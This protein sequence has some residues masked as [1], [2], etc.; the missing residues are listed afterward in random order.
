MLRRKRGPGDPRSRRSLGPAAWL[1]CATLLVAGPAHAP[2]APS[3]PPPPVSASRLQSLL[4]RFVDQTYLKAFRH[5]GDE[6][7]FDHGHF[8][9]A[10]ADP[11]AA[12]V[13]ILYHTQ[14]LAYYAAAGS[15]YGWLDPDGRNW[16]QWLKDGRVENARRYLSP[17]PEPLPYDPQ[18]LKS[19]HTIL[20]EMLEPSAFGGRLLRSRQI[21]FTRQSCPSRLDPSSMLVIRMPGAGR[22]VCLSLSQY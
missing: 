13:A 9:F 8:L 14:E 19:H 1:L 21:V 5:L 15:A 17:N 11:G 22:R 16:I 20:A 2:A 6:R 18:A 10:S 4:Q 7:D 3:A 12:P